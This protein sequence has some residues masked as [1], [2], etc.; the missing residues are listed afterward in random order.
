M[1][2][3]V[4]AMITDTIKTILRYNYGRLGL[5]KSPISEQ[6]IINISEITIKMPPIIT[7]IR[8]LPFLLITSINKINKSFYKSTISMQINAF[9]VLMEKLLMMN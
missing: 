2:S 4:N 1:F 5:R 8:R 6:Y 7:K 3:D 9:F